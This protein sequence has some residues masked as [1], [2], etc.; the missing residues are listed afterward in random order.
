MLHWGIILNFKFFRL[1]C[2]KVEFEIMVW[3]KL[4]DSMVGHLSNVINIL[5]S[6][7][8]GKLK[9]AMHYGIC[10]HSILLFS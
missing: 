5:A 2:N 4:N 9:N 7:V 10:F 1:Q 6:R 3:V 8:Q